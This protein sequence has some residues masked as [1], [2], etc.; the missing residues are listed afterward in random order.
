MAIHICDRCGKP[1]PDDAALCPHCGAEQREDI[2]LNKI[3]ETIDELRAFC[4]ARRM[5]LERMRFFIGEDYRGARAFGIYKDADGDC[6]VYKNKADGSR[7]VRYKGPDEKRAV[8]E[9]YEKLKAETELRRENSPSGASRSRAASH[10]RAKASDPPPAARG[11]I[12]EACSFLW[13]PAAIVL[14]V[15]LGFVLTVR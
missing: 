3:P 7:A 13:K 5:P 14:A 6:V 15:A 8:R 10:R 2:R 11:R 4:D 1:I 12:G 9:L